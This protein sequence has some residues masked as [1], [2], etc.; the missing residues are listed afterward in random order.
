MQLFIGNTP[1]DSVMEKIAITVIL[2]CD[3]RPLRL[4]LDKI[5]RLMCARRPIRYSTQGQVP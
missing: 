4:P 5:V 2:C 1:S 3:V